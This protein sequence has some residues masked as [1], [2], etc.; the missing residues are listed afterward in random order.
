MSTLAHVM[1]TQARGDAGPVRHTIVH[2]WWT[3]GGNS[4]STELRVAYQVNYPSVWHRGLGLDPEL[5]IH[6]I[7]REINHEWIE[8]QLDEA[9]RDAVRS[10]IEQSDAFSAPCDED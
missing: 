6:A 3:L 2:L 10:E 4:G 1:Q 5:V 8:A 7:E 9:Q